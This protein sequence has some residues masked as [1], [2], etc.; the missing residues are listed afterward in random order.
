MRLSGKAC[1]SQRKHFAFHSFGQQFFDSFAVK[2]EIELLHG[3]C[4]YVYTFSEH[5]YVWRIN[6]IVEYPVSEV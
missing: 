1:F 4:T 2:T 6:T 3:I 5:S